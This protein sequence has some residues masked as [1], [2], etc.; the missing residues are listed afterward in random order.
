MLPAGLRQHLPD[1]RVASPRVPNHVVRVAQNIPQR[2]LHVISPQLLPRHR[3]AH[4]PANHTPHDHRAAIAQVNHHVRALQQAATHLRILPLRNPRG[5]L[6]ERLNVRLKAG[7]RSPV[8]TPM[9]RIHLHMRNV[10]DAP[11]PRRKR[12]LAATA[13]AGNQDAHAPL[14]LFSRVSIDKKVGCDPAQQNTQPTLNGDP[15]KTR[16]SQ[17]GA[18]S[19]RLNAPPGNRRTP[20]TP[21]GAQDQR[22]EKI[23]PRPSSSA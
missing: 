20:H 8:R 9:Q 2:R 16:A 14:P 18:Q 23:T 10:Q 21:A 22:L 6:D 3:A 7:A 19:S 11:Q 15:G 4:R 13:R 12:C 17:P 5:P 1:V